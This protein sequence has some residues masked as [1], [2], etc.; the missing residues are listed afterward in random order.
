MRTGAAGSIH[1]G[2]CTRR[3]I[4]RQP[5][6]LRAVAAAGGVGWRVR[7]MRPVFVMR[8]AVVVWS[9]SPGVSPGMGRTD[10]RWDRWTAGWMRGAARREAGG[11]AVDAGDGAADA[12][13]GFTGRKAGS[14]GFV[15]G[16]PP[17]GVQDDRSSRVTA[18]PMPSAA[19]QGG[20]QAVAALFAVDRRVGCVVVGRPRVTAPPMPSAALQGGKRAVAALFAVDRRVGCV[21]VGRVG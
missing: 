12:I 13:G 8:A 1:D 21:V 3:A 4:R 16:G 20:E 9:R 10:I 14:R 6:R 2:R 18:P 5:R 11:C 15:R 19:L 7:R 17:R